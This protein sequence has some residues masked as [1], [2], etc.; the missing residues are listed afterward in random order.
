[1]LTQRRRLPPGLRMARVYRSSRDRGRRMGAPRPAQRRARLSSGHLTPTPGRR[2]RPRLDLHQAGSDH[3]RRRGPVPRRARERVQAV[4]RPRARREL[5]QREDGRRAGP[6]PV[7][8]VG[9][10]DV[11]HRAPRRRLHRTGARSDAAHGRARRRQGAT[12]TGREA[13]PPRP[14]GD[15]MAGPAARRSHPDRGAREPACARRAVRRDDHRGARLPTRGAEHARR[16]PRARAS[17]AS[18]ATSC[19]DPTPRSSRAACS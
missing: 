9:V 7:V 18:G 3:L 6:P 13:R 2:H 14:R 11:R 10:R 16:R 15:V 4:P 5:R 1:M 8:G 19:P 17:S 12:T